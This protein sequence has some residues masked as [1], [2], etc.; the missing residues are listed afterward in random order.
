MDLLG[1]LRCEGI[2]L[3]LSKEDN[4]PIPVHLYWLLKEL[5]TI[6]D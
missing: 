6:T 3:I 1:P 5:Q 4:E 2:D